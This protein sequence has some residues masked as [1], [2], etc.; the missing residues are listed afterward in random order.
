MCHH[1]IRRG[2]TQFRIYW[3]DKDRQLESFWRETK[4]GDVLPWED[5]A[6]EAERPLAISKANRAATKEGHENKEQED[7]QEGDEGDPH[8][9]VIFGRRRSDSVVVDW[10]NKVIFVLEFKCTSDQRQDYREGGES[11]ATIQ[12]DVLMRSL[13]K[14]AEDVGGAKWENQMHKTQSYDH[15]SHREMVSAVTVSHVFP[16]M[17]RFGCCCHSQ[18][19]CICP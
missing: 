7:G 2:E 1:Q 3:E 10:T 18:T 5:M 9:G 6:D 11:R 17:S 4:I 16:M 15:T 12:H 14:V 13:E 8:N 19:P